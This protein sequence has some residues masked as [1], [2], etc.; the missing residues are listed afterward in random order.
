MEY[1]SG[2][3]FSSSLS[4]KGKYFLLSLNSLQIQQNDWAFKEVQFQKSFPE[5]YSSSKT[6][7]GVAL[8][9]WLLKGN[10]THMDFLNF[11][12][13]AYLVREVEQQYCQD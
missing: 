6:P 5:P 1:A 7:S 9:C 13:A 2:K 4:E 10:K 8:F 3:T 12:K 11:L